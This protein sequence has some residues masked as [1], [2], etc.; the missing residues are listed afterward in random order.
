MSSGKVPSI[1]FIYSLCSSNYKAFKALSC[2]IYWSAIVF[3]CFS[4]ALPIEEYVN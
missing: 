1:D 2:F 4:N 3:I